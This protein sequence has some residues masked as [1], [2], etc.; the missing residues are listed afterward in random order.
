MSNTLSRRSLFYAT[1]TPFFIFYALFC[2]VLYPYRDLIQPSAG[3]INKV[4]DIFKNHEIVVKVLDVLK[5]AKG[6]KYLTSILQNWTF[7]LFYIVSELFGSVGVSVL[8]W[9]LANEIITIDQAKVGTL[10]VTTYYY[11]YYYYYNHQHDSNNN[12]ES[13]RNA[14]IPLL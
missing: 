6:L 10:R 9:Q 4:P 14:Y 11:Y 8:F 1:C 5:Q 3:L 7:S 12:K 13:G 2:T